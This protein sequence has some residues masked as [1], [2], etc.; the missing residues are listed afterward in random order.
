MKR[1][2]NCIFCKIVAGDI[3]CEKLHEDEASIAFMDIGPVAKGHCLLICKDHYEALDDMP[4]EAA[5]DVLK[6]LPK[7]VSAVK[8]ATGCD[9]VNVLQN[10]GRIAGQLVGHVHFHIIPRYEAT[11]GFRFNWPAQSGDKQELHELAEKIKN[12]M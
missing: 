7:L 3:P 9:G 11:E 4:A 12:E 1:D 10:N 8:K 5:G 2:E 6:N